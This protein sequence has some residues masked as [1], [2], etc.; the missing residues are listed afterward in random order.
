MNQKE[1]SKSSIE[2]RVLPLG[3]KVKRYALRCY[4][5]LTRNAVHTVPRG[6]IMRLQNPVFGESYGRVMI[7]YGFGGVVSTGDMLKKGNNL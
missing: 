5:L 3:G 6:V 7:R 2:H 4:C 1:N